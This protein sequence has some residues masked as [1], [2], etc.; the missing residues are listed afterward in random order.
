[1][2]GRQVGAVVVVRLV[3]AARAHAHVLMHTHT[4][5]C[6]STHTHSLTQAPTLTHTH[7]LQHTRTYTHMHAYA[8]STMRALVWAYINDC[9]TTNW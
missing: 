4:H 7:I 1:M 5:M 2:M 6:I 9:W 3:Q 8:L